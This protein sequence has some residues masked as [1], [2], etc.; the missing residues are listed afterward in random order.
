MFVFLSILK[1]NNWLTGKKEWRFLAI[2][3][4]YLEKT[5]VEDIL[6]VIHNS[7]HCCWY[8]L[9]WLSFFSLFFVIKMF[10]TAEP[11]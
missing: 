7:S 6:R 9:D 4:Y 1:P 10:L 2:C 8:A 11:L 3:W 5:S